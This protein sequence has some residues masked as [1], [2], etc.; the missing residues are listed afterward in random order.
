[1]KKNGTLI[2]ALCLLISSAAYAAPVPDWSSDSI[3]TAVA[4]TTLYTAEV[5]TDANGRYV[6]GNKVKT[7]TFSY[8]VGGKRLQHI[9]YDES[10]KAVSNTVYEYAGNTSAELVLTNIK[11]YMG[12]RNLVGVE[13]VSYDVETGL[14]TF[15]K[16]DAEGILISK[17]VYTSDVMG[18]DVLAEVFDSS[19]TLIERTETVYNDLGSKKAEKKT[20]CSD[21]SVTEHRFEYDDDGRILKEIV[22][23]DD[24]ITLVMLYESDVSGNWIRKE[25]Y[26]SLNGRT[27]KNDLKLSE[28]VYRLIVPYG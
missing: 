16:Y 14:T 18:R 27:E 12:G 2:A 8:E 1:M 10:S 11:E 22:S 21:G 4:S 19:G 5:K 15:D 28:I 26:E 25:V 13:N 20:N 9:V 7:D 6:E 17:S 3:C 24:V 23:K